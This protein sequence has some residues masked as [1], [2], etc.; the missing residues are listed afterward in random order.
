MP[1]SKLEE[2]LESIRKSTVAEKVGH[3]HDLARLSYHDYQSRVSSSAEFKSGVIRYVRHHLSQI[4]ANESTIPDER[5]YEIAVP[6]LEKR[7]G[8]MEDVGYNAVMGLEGGMY[9][10]LDVVSDGLRREDEERYIESVF[11]KYESYPGQIIQIMQEFVL[12]VRTHML[13]GETIKPAEELAKNWKRVLRE[14]S[15]L[16]D[17]LSAQLG[18][19]GV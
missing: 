4:E 19:Y 5:A 10:I 1:Q 9:T 14:H 17:E 18:R 12:R 8:N 15:Q 11:Q 2:I 3:K 7:W 16:L 6:F 13:P